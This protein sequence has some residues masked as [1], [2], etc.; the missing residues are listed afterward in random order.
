MLYADHTLVSFFIILNRALCVSCIVECIEGVCKMNHTLAVKKSPYSDPRPPVS[1]RKKC[2]AP[3]AKRNILLVD[4]ETLLLMLLKEIIIQLGY[5]P[6]LAA[7]G[8]QALEKLSQTAVDLVITDVQMP[9][10]SGIELLQ[11]VKAMQPDIPVLL[12]SGSNPVAIQKAADRYHA[13]AF[14]P[15]PFKFAQLTENIQRLM[16]S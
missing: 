13:D 9:G 12:L 1:V 6:I 7:D 3:L 10:L 5:N 14:L 16:N 4:D 2:H 11:R 8:Q 15:K